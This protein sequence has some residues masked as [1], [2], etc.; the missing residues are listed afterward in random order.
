MWKAEPG[1]RRRLDNKV[2]AR[3]VEL[4]V[5]DPEHSL[6]ARDYAPEPLARYDEAHSVIWDWYVSTSTCKVNGVNHPTH[7]LLIPRTRARSGNGSKQAVGSTQQQY[8]RPLPGAGQPTA[9]MRGA[10]SAGTKVARAAAP[11]PPP[12]PP[13]AVASTKLHRGKPIPSGIFGNFFTGRRNLVISE[14]AIELSKLPGA[15]QGKGKGS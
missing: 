3:Q 5:Y 2:V 14:P 12:L 13:T 4:M 10:L 8:G 6:T 1:L 9:S 15:Q 11:S 7:Y